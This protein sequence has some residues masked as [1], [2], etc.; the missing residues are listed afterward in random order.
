MKVENVAKN[1][2]YMKTEYGVKRE[3]IKEEFKAKLEQSSNFMYILDDD[4][5]D[6][7]FVGTSKKKIKFEAIEDLEGTLVEGVQ[8]FDKIN[9]DKDGQSIE[10]K[11]YKIYNPM[12]KKRAQDL[13]RKKEFFVCQSG[14]KANLNKH[15]TEP[16]E[17]IMK[18]YES[19]KDKGRM[20][21]LFILL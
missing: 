17:K 21:F 3:H 16:L 4:D 11:E 10:M 1:E 14:V 18:A 9:T 12:H 13:D 20:Y 6:V 8:S 19:F 5:E 7:T 2:E 15:I